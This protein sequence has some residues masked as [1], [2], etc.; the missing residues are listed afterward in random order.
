TGVAIALIRETRVG[1][2]RGADFQVGEQ[3][4][5]CVDRFRSANG[6]RQASDRQGVRG[7]TKTEVDISATF[8]RWHRLSVA[9]PRARIIA[10]ASRVSLRPYCCRTST[11]DVCQLR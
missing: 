8:K 6:E 2:P 7:W 10:S 11:T 9:D 1:L 3:D 5:C 4:P